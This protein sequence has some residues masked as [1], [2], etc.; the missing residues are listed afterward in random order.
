MNFLIVDDNSKHAEAACIYI[1]QIKYCNII[2]VANDGNEAISFLHKQKILP[3][4]VLLDIEMKKLNGLTTLLYI[5]TTFPAIKVI[6]FSSHY[7]TYVI[8]DA[9]AEGADAFI[10]KYKFKQYN[11]LINAIQ[12]IQKNEYYWDERITDFTKDLL[13][14][15]LAE[16]KEQLTN[17][18]KGFNLSK[19]QEQVIIL[20][21]ARINISEMATIL[22]ISEHTI[23]NSLYNLNQKLNTPFGRNGIFDT[24]FMYGFL[25]FPRLKK[26]S[27]G[28]VKAIFIS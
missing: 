13:K 14:K 10:W 8:N 3:T 19:R 22:N 15:A 27:G 21:A 5:K 12:H 20:N 28:G 17:F 11:Y 6:I 25:K 2:G 23:K 7:E 9:F 24:S 26:R 4:C 16:R 18:R 1:K